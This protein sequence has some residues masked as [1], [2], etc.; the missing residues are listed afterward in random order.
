MPQIE[1]REEI[2][3]AA[4]RAR[5]I[6][7]AP[8]PFKS[9]LLFL[10]GTGVRPIEAREARVEKCDLEKGIIMVPNK[11]RKK[12]GAKERP[13]FLSTA[14]IE[15]CRGLIGTRTEGWLLRN[16][17]GE[18]WKKCTLQARMERLCDDMGITKG[19]CLYSSHHEFASTA[20]N[21]KGMHVAL[22]AIQLGHVDTKMLLRHYLHH[23]HEAMRKAL[24]SE[25]EIMKKSKDS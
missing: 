23:D 4:D 24:D 1:R 17:F 2:M 8:E 16:K 15:L 5:L 9:A 3:S 6:E 25:G 10:E 13:V 7:A 19:A 18:Q 21:E 22:Q 12:T 14:M 11:T 20:I